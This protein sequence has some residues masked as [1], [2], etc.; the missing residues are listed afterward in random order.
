MLKRFLLFVFIFT[1]ITTAQ[2]KVVHFKKLQEFLPKMEVQKFTRSKP[3][4]S[5][6]TVMGFTTSLAE[7]R[8]E[9]NI[10]E[11]D[12]ETP[13]RSVSIKITDATLYQAALISY[14]FLTDYESESESGYEKSYTVNGKY[15]GILR[16]STGDYKEATLTFAVAQRFLIEVDADNTDDVNFVLSFVNDIKLEDLAILRA[17]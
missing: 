6:Q 7:V 10:P 5:T 8:Y 12:Y 9:E 1:A 2:E 4:G 16:V 13:Q 11:T 17:E 15:R 14:S 3:S